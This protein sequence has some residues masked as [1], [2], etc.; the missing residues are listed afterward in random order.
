MATRLQL[1]DLRRAWA[2]Q[3]PEL[4]ELIVR[5]AEQP[6]EPAETPPREGAFTF[7]AFLAEI[8]SRVFHKKP[9]E[10]QAHLRQEKMKA[11]EAST[12]EVPLTDRLKSHE[13]LLALWNDGSPFARSILLKVIAAIP[14]VYGPWRAL[15]QIF[16]E[17]E[18]RNDTEIWGALVARFD[19][20]L[21]AFVST[22]IS[23]RT[24]AYLCRRAWRYL[25][26][27]GLTLPACYADVAS[28]VLIH[29]TDDT[30]IHTWVASHI[31]YHESKKYGPPPASICRRRSGATC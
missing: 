28:D 26:H 7:D 4:A 23:R 20:A 22:P 9:K 10:E 2:A 21:A 16:K 6:D 24:I 3:D 8:R 29:Y 18:K 19:M 27:I 31:F 5:L 15:K 14:L 17:A 1:D 30:Q 12:A 25:R 13:I 11:L